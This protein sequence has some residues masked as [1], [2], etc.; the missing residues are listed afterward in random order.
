MERLHKSC[1]QLIWL[2]PLLRYQGFEPRSKGVKAILPHIDQFRT[3]HNLNS[4]KDLADI[5]SEPMGAQIER[6][7]FAA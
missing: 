6:R 1:R 7:S 4:L 5:L 2:N 3:I